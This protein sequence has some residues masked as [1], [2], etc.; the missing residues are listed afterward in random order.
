MVFSSITQKRGI[1]TFLVENL[2]QFLN[3]YLKIYKKNFSLN[4]KGFR[5]RFKNKQNLLLLPTHGNY[6]LCLGNDVSLPKRLVLEFSLPE[7]SPRSSKSRFINYNIIRY[8]NY[9]QST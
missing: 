7:I 2:M 3:R 1:S 5:K 8:A 9:Y 6:N 4:L